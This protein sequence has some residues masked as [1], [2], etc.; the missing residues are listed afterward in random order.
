VRVCVF[1]GSLF[2]N[3]PAFAQAARAFGAE[4]ARRGHGLVYGGAA[5]GLMGV[6]ADAALA[7]GAEVVG[8]LPR[9]LMHSEIAHTGLTELRIVPTLHERKAVMSAL[10]D[11]V[12]ALP[13]GAGTLDELFEAVTWRQLGLHDKPIGLLEVD[14][15]YSALLAFLRHGVAQG[16]IPRIVEERLIVRNDAS[17]LLDA[18]E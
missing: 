2:G 9:A 6:C 13:G 7:G 5:R 18:L 10:C 16:F 8:V 17:S 4:L 14:G 3:A 11:A 12:V 1:A 15:Y